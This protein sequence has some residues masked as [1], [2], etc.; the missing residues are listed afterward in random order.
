MYNYNMEIVSD[1]NV[2]KEKINS[3]LKIKININSLLYNNK[4]LKNNRV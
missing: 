4:T 3:F 2:I 1:N